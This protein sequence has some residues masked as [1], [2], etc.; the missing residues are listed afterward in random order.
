MRPSILAV[1]VLGQRL[2]GP[3]GELVADPALDEEAMSPGSEALKAPAIVS[4]VWWRRFWIGSASPMY[5]HIRSSASGASLTAMRSTM[6]LR[7]SSRSS[8]RSRRLRESM[9][10]RDRRIV[11]IRCRTS[12]ARSAVP[13]APASSRRSNRRAAGL[14]M[15]ISISSSARRSVSEGLQVPG[16][17]SLLR[18][19][20]VGGSA[21]QFGYA[22]TLIRRSRSRNSWHR[23]QAGPGETRTRERSAEVAAA[24][25]GAA[26]NTI[27]AAT[28]GD[29][30]LNKGDFVSKTD[31]LGSV[32]R[33]S[34]ESSD[35]K[36][37]TA[38][39]IHGA[40]RD[41]K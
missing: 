37:L 30:G 23:G 17:E 21:L 13:C 26:G 24:I 36:D 10:A 5:C 40:S 8:T 20:I 39:R 16:V 3:L 29:W 9:T 2:G 22:E 19:H 11:A 1:G 31:A 25:P 27:Q 18:C 6:V 38:G 34:G 33:Q 15:Q 41:G 35:T 12:M 32:A 14:P 7:Q 4:S 28:Q